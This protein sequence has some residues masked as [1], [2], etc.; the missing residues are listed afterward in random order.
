VTTISN[1]QVKFLTSFLGSCN[2]NAAFTQQCSDSGYAS[3]IETC[4]GIKVIRT[5]VNGV[6]LWSHIYVDTAGVFGIYPRLSCIRQI[7]DD[8]FIVTG[9]ISDHGFYMRIE[10]Q[11]NVVW[12]KEFNDGDPTVL[13]N[14]V[15]MDTGGFVI[16]GFT[17][18]PM[19]NDHAY[20]LTIDANGNILP[21]Q[22]VANSST[23]VKNFAKTLDGGIIT[24][25]SGLSK[26]GGLT[27]SWNRGISFY[28]YVIVPA[29][30]TTYIL[31]NYDSIVKFDSQGNQL[32]NIGLGQGTIQDIAY[33]NSLNN[34]GY[35]ILSTEFIN[36][37]TYHYDKDSNVHLTRTDLNGNILWTKSFSN[38]TYT[39]SMNLVATGDEGLA[40]TG[41]TR[42]IAEHLA[43]IFI[44]TDSLGNIQ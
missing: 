23:G 33:V 31:S 21:S 10:S 34:P 4:F 32:W 7:S 41:I 8:G 16:N 28:P 3:A 37:Q 39:L 6:T 12:M 36:N 24:F 19:S 27:G 38:F 20:F 5:D 22:L 26:L 35:A 43:V 25:S 2:A 30:D 1:G 17:N 44:K 40:I 9:S 11:G 13:Y 15:E 29:A 42:S 14:V 18:G